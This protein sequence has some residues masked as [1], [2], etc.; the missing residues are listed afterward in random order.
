[1]TDDGL[2]P[3]EALTEAINT[4]RASRNEGWAATWVMEAEAVLAAL[5]E[6][7]RLVGPEQAARDRVVEAARAWAKDGGAYRVIVVNDSNALLL[8]AVEALSDE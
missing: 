7:W 8:D 5:P 6:G 2:T 1:M 4:V 3:A